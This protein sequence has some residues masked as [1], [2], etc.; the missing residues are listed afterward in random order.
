MYFTII[1]F[2]RKE[3]WGLAKQQL[4]KT[5]AAKTDHVSLILRTHMV[6]GEKELIP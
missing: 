5:P 1:Y 3:M 4:V 6:K 2:L